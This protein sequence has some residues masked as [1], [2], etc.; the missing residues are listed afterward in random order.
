MA[1]H[2]EYMFVDARIVCL[3]MK[4]AGF[5]LKQ[6]WWIGYTSHRGKNTATQGSGDKGKIYTITI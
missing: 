2:P 1:W 6:K 5:R 4:L 3:E